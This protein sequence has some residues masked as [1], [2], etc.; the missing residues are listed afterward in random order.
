MMLTL[1]ILAPFRHGAIGALDELETVFSTVR[2]DDHDLGTEAAQ[3][4]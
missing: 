4:P 1:A 3:S 2:R